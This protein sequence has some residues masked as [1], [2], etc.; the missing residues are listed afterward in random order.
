[1]S[2]N[3]PFKTGDLV[4]VFG[5]SIGK[6][7]TTADQVTVCRELSV[8]ECDL[9]VEE[10]TGRFSRLGMY[11]VPMKLCTKLMINAAYL[12]T[13]KSLTPSMGDLVLSYSR[14]PFKNEEPTQTTGI[15]YKT[16]YRLGKMHMCTLISGEE[17]KEVSADNLIVLQRKSQ[18]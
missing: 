15:L 13:E 10:A 7:G 12:E 17:I 18:D 3:V 14:E 6:E 8:G 11:V 9:L 5:G 2:T 16:T 4:A 1:M